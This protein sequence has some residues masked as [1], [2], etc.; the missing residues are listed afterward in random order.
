M[1]EISYHDAH[2]PYM[3]AVVIALDAA[4]LTVGDWFADANDP[5]DGCI[6]LAER[7][8]DGDERSVCWHEEKGWF[9]GFGAENSQIDVIWWI[10][11]DVLPDPAEVVEAVRLC[12][13]GDYS[14]ASLDHGYYRDFEDED[15]GFE[16]L[17][18][19]YAGGDEDA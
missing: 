3:R 18:A 17:L 5:R 10:C 13:A 6:T 9:Y 12:V 15:D 7:D 1:P 4:G 8:E 16:E 2:E 19:A 14:K 11:D